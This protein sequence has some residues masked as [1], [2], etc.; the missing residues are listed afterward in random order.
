MMKKKNKRFL[1][2]FLSGVLFACLI[3]SCTYDYFV[4]ETNYKVFVPEVAAGTVSDCYVAVYDEAGTL[5]RSRRAGTSNDD[6]RVKAGLFSFRL[7]PG[8][9]TAHCYADVKEMQLEEAAS[10]DEAFIALK[11]VTPP[12]GYDGE[13]A[14]GLP[15]EMLFRKLLPE[16]GNRFEPRVDTATLERYVGKITV[17]F[18]NLPVSPEVARVQLEA[19]GV[20]TRQYFGRDTLSSRFTEEDYIF[21]EAPVSPAIAGASWEM[22]GCY[23]PSIDGQVMRLNLR[24]IDA[25]GKM[26]NNIAV[27]VVDPLTSL[28]LPLLHGRRIVLEIDTYTVVG[29]GIAGWDEDIKHSGKDI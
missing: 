19:T 28:P 21:D 20:A 1:V 27:E 18:K 14:H 3:V 2:V 26:L 22:S 23:F 8:K 11:R 6:P 25:E 10:R 15:S 13:H 9:Y 24:F 5:V 29:I 16:I 7:P 12:A 4:D 17:L